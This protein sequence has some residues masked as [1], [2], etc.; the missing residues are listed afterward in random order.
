MLGERFS[1]WER[2]LIVV[3]L[4]L[5]LASR[6]YLLG[7]R[8]MSH[9]ESLHTKYS[10][11]LYSGS[12]YQH[13]PMMHGPILFHLTALAYFIFGVNDFAA[14]LFPAL[15]GI[16]LIFMPLLFRRY[17][18][19]SGALIA[20]VLL[21]LS[22]S[23]TYHS[24]YIRHDIFLMAFGVL[25]VWT[26][27]KYLEEGRA[28]W[29]YWFAGCFALMYTT[30]EGYYIY[31]LI[32]GVL[33]FLP[34]LDWVLTARWQRPHLFYAFLVVIVLVVVL[35]GAFGLALTGSESQER[36]LDAAGNTRVADLVLPLW[37]RVAAVAAL[38]LL[39]AA[40]VLVFYGLGEETI[41]HARLFDAL[42]VM[43]TLVLPLGS[44]FL[45]SM[46][47]FDPLDYSTNGLLHSALIIVPIFLGA[48]MLGLWWDARRW[49]IIAAIFYGIFFTLYTT[50]FTNGTGIA[51]GLVGALGY[52]MAQQGVQRGQQPWYY[53]LL[54][55]SLYEY[56]V[57]LGSIGA[58]IGAI[59]W[60]F[61]RPANGDSQPTAKALTADPPTPALP[62]NMLAGSPPSPAT[63]LPSGDRLFP[64]FL[65][66]WTVLAWIAFSYAGEK[67]PWLTVHLAL[68]S[69]LLSAWGLGRLV[70]KVS[71]SR[72]RERMG[73]LVPLA[74]PFVVTAFV[75]LTLSLSQLFPLLRQGVSPAGLSLTQ[76]EL[77][78]RALGGLLALLGFGGLLLWA[79]ER[80]GVGTALRLSAL[81]GALVLAVF[82]ARTMVMLNYIN[83]DLAKE[84]LV[85][86]HSTPDVKIALRQIDDVS[87][88]TTG[89]PHEVKVAYS[90]D[91]S[92]PIGW[93]MT[94]YPNAYFYGTNPDPDTLR[95]CPVVIAGREQWNAVEAVLG[96]QYIHFDYKYLWWPIQDYFNLTPQRIRYALTDP[97]MRAALLDILWDRDYR[98]YALA[99]N[100]TIDMNQWPLRKEFR[101]YVRQDLA[102]QTWSYRLGATGMQVSQPAWV[103]ATSAP[104]PYASGTR[105]LP[106]V[107][108]IALPGASSRGL[109]VAPDGSLYVSDT[110]NHRIW[111]VSAQG[112]VLG[113]WG[114]AGTGPGQFN[115]PWG[116]AVDQDGNVYVADT[117]NHRVQKFDPQG[118]F[119][120]QWGR[121][122]LYAVGDPAGA[123]A[124]Y[125]PRGIA[126]GPDGNLYV[127]D[128]GNKRIQV[129]TPEGQFVRDFGGSGRE[130]GQLD[131]PV[132]LAVGTG[133]EVFVA[134][135]W[136]QRVQVF[137][138]DGVFRRQWQVP[139]WAANPEEKPYIALDREGRAFVSDP[140]RAR[141]LAFVGDG[142]FL[143]SVGK[144]GEIG[145]T[146][147]FPQGVALSAN[148]ETLYVA[149][150]HS[151]RILGY[152][153][154]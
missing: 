20:S 40:V 61:R 54:T 58:G 96:S 113:S 35:L 11:Y 10:W 4:V 145:D 87:W 148:G 125:G 30:M 12:G 108:N 57:G 151:G 73:W 47:G 7:A 39:V 105:E 23:I 136:N 45:I 82:T 74:L 135:T 29:L 59:V 17:L 60:L 28:R 34:L 37:G 38:V 98:K 52:W 129:F 92:W 77:V 139:V 18:G 69:S 127:T 90:E 76:L 104:D 130:L 153:L 64:F 6:F 103:E 50:I 149:D 14:R 66:G 111:H 46:A 48:I 22:P 140:L 126:V 112:A 67:M 81:T 36:P 97:T 8:T 106:V 62:T 31:T 88:R 146:L 26:L 63:A 133:G 116:V 100:Q 99:T 13:N 141:V 72:V 43:G 78:G 79:A 147:G 134:D 80:V 65:S 115:E 101:L 122:G 27:F 152:Q 128:T 138:S 21:L 91:G 71:W 42:M 144:Y 93:Y 86:A 24:R 2:I 119:L 142:A 68:P 41:R 33:F 32:F 44:A 25:V 132:G 131:E 118:T 55:M 137:S 15:F 117:W 3:I 49:P 95:S 51:S 53:Y 107:V 16:A 102:E 19:R 70:A 150:A 94:A 83:Y 110:T 1:R 114:K 120:L 109:A 89:T 9:D 124:F 123:G 154:P 85:Y 121:N 56:L 143:W 84:F 5:A 75:V